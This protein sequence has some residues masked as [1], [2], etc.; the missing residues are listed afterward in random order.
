MK[1]MEASHLNKIYKKKCISKYILLTFN[2]ERKCE[3]G[4]H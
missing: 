2:T 3:P 1:D 4:P